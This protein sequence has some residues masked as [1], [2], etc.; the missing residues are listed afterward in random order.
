MNKKDL[1]VLS[2]IFL[3]ISLAYIISSFHKTGGDTVLIQVDGKDFLHLSLDED[4]IVKVSGPLGVSIVEIK[5]GRV[6]MLSSPCPDK[7]CIKEGYIDKAGQVII[8][9]PNRIVI[10]I[11]GRAGLDALTY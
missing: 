2:I 11:E 10:K 1:L 5:D 8:C 3:I 6:R 7:L 4:R 9:I